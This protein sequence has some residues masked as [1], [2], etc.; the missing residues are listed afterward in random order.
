MLVRVQDF[1]N[2]HRGRFPDPGVAREAFTALGLAIEGLMAA[3]IARRSATASARSGRK[4]AAGKVLGDLLLKAS[5]TARVLRAHGHSVPSFEVPR[6][7]HAMLA[8]ARQFERDA[9]PFEAAFVAHGMAPGRI[10][11][12]AT[13]FEVAMRDR[14]LS[15]ADILT[16]QMRMRELFTSALDHART[17]DVVIRNELAGD[18]AI[19]AV[20]QRARRLDARRPR[21]ASATETPAPATDATEE[22][23]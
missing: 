13:A 8:A 20:W 11:E 1:G 16:A 7:N 5:Q 3:D 10:A 18:K 14:G 6:T 23:A 2:T 15:R 17:L 22:A 4:T 19:Q 21:G 9:T 12:A